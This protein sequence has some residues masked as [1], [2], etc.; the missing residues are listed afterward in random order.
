MPEGAANEERLIT[1]ARMCMYERDR[2][3]EV[4]ER[5]WRIK[6]SLPFQLCSETDREFC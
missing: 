6:E 5:A 2:E 4:R 1:D 3:S